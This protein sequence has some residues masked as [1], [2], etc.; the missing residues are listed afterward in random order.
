MKR[1]LLMAVVLACSVE[2]KAQSIEGWSAVGAPDGFKGRDGFFRAWDFCKDITQ[3]D[4]WRGK[5]FTICM[6]DLGWM[7]SKP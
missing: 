1:I 3:N 6:L 4:H 5:R 2:M 7:W